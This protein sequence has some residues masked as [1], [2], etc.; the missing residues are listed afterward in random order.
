[1][2]VTAVSAFQTPDVWNVFGHSWMQY[3]FGTYYQTGRADARF[4]ASMDVE[5]TNRRNWAVNGSRACIEGAST[6]GFRRF[7][8]GSKKPQRGGPYTADGG[9]AIFSYGINDLGLVGFTTQIKD[10]YQ[11][12]MRTMISRWRMGVIYENDF[13][14]GTRTSYGAGFGSVA[15]VGYTS[16]DTAH[17]CTA[18]TNANFTL[19]LPAD[20]NGETVGVCLVGAGG[21]A[22]GIV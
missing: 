7:F 1:M 22:G 14:V 18:T 19:T 11:H 17:W 3:A 4:F 10:A 12:A 9:A 2:P 13:Q 6:G 15:A 8:N 16:N 20:Y 21:V 5:A